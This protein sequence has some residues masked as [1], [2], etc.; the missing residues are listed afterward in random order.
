VLLDPGLIPVQ[1]IFGFF[2]I[3]IDGRWLVDDVLD[4]LSFSLP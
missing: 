2:L 4:E 3:E 1:K